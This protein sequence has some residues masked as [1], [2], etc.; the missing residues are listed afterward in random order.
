MK[1]N[2]I[3]VDD[4]KMSREVLKNLV[5]KTE[6]LELVGIANDALQASN[7]LAQNNTDIIFLDVEMPEMT[8]MDLIK[9][10]KDMPQIILVTSNKDYAIEAFEYDV[11]DYLLKPINPQRFL[12]SVIRIKE[13]IENQKNSFQQD[14]KT[15]FIK[16][17]TQLTKLEKKSIL[18]IE[19]YGD[20]VNIYTDD[21]KYTIHSTMK[22]IAN[23]LEKSQFMR[24][25]R[26]YIVQ[27]EKIDS[28]DESMIFIE[29][30]M[31]PIGGSFKEDLMKR[32]NL[33]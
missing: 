26:S 30:K 11:A 9:S 19:A 27:L 25:H 18:Y 4:D 16:D 6:H 10:L 8:G 7:L 31:I 33:F 3:V 2:C 28:I 24:V 32:L 29:R 1:L 14:D 22:N 15:I 12:K 21:S 13:K 20:Y 23:K 5:E 17:G